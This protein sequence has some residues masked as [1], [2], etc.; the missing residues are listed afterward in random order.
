[1][2]LRELP[3]NPTEGRPVTTITEAD[4]HYHD[5]MAEAIVRLREFTKGHVAYMPPELAH[6]VM[7]VIPAVRWGG[8]IGDADLNHQIGLDL[9]AG[10][11]HGGYHGY[12]HHHIEDVADEIVGF[13]LNELDR[14]L[15]AA[16]GCAKGGE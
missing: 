15:D 5:T 10:H 6:A 3:L 13:Y 1:L 7:L 4:Q 16:L 2:F 14:R 8:D 11:E 12:D 9:V